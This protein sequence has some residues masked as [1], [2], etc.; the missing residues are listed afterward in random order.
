MT[1][2]TSSRLEAQRIINEKYGL[3][4]EQNG[5]QPLH[6]FSTRRKPSALRNANAFAS[7]Y[8]VLS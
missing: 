1:S 8:K 5:L 6:Q 2:A 7:P 4:N 3:L